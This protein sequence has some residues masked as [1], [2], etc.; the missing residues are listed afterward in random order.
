MIKGD[1][2]KWLP[3]IDV[4]RVMFGFQVMIIV[5]FLV[6]RS[7]MK[8]RAKAVVEASKAH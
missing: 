4:N 3:A 2:V 6:V 8:A 7:V 5:F 1:E